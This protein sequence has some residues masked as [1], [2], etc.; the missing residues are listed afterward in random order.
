MKNITA[1][2]FKAKCLAIMDQVAHTREGVTI[3][4]HGRAV[5]Q[6]IA[7]PTTDEE[8]PQKTLKGSVEF[9]EDVVG[10]VLPADAWESLDG[11]R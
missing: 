3:L 10:P 7:A 6:L 11:Q 4:K 8:Y 5:A 2:E 1:T 9:L